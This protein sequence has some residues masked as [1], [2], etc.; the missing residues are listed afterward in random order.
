MIRLV[1]PNTALSSPGV[2]EQAE[3][4]FYNSYLARGMTVFDVGANIG[5]LTLLFSQL[6]DDGQVHAFEAS[7][8]TFHRL[9]N[10]CQVESR[11]NV[12]LNH[13]AVA[14]HEGT[15]SLQVYDDDHSGWNSLAQRP[16]QNYGIDIKPVHVEVVES[17]TV[18][19][20]CA[21]RHVDH[22]DLLKIDV[23]GAE[24]QVLRG[25][26][27]MLRTKSIRC[28]IFEFGQATF[29]MGDSPDDIEAY[30]A[31][32]GYRVRNVVDSDPAFP[33]RTRAATARFSMQVMVPAL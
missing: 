13:L 15:V 28:C 16:L 1:A 22:I 27:Q 31:L 9:V 24:L 25:A 7:A 14:D 21:D 2:V 33:G 32:V 26:E 18:D 30:I 23:E 20:Y 19:R 6:V 17:I 10:R 11:P 4:A 29:D 3:R 12:I 8:G 5:D